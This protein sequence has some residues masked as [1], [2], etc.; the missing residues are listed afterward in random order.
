MAIKWFNSKQWHF[1]NNE[2][3]K[4]KKKGMHPALVVGESNGMFANLGLTHSDKRG[5]HKNILL[6]KNP[7]RGDL[8][9]SYLRNDL[10]LHSKE[11]MKQKLPGFKLSS[12]DI[13]KVQAIINKHKKR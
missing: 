11:H 3:R 1:R 5:H 13:P 7:K 10:Q 6:S 4:T 2:K 12:K 8:K 9:P